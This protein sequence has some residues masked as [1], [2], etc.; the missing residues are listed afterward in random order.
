P[1]G[2][3]QKDAIKNQQIRRW[4]ELEDFLGEIWEGRQPLERE[5]WNGEKG[6]VEVE[7]TF[8]NW[9]SFLEHIL[10]S[11][12]PL[13]RAIDRV[14][15][16]E[17]LELILTASERLTELSNGE[18]IHLVNILYTPDGGETQRSYAPAGV[19]E[20]IERNLQLS[21]PTAAIKNSLSPYFSDLKH[22]YDKLLFLDL[23]RLT[24]IPTHQSTPFTPRLRSIRVTDFMRG[25]QA[26]CQLIHV[27]KQMTREIFHSTCFSAWR[28]ENERSFLKEKRRWEKQ[29]GRYARPYLDYLD[30][31]EENQ[32][33]VFW[34]Q[35]GEDLLLLLVTGEVKR[36]TTEAFILNPF[37]DH[38]SLWHRELTEGAHRGLPWVTA[39]GTLSALI[40]PLSPD[41]S[42]QLIG[43]MRDFRSLTRPLLGNYRTLR[44]SQGPQTEQ[45]LALAFYPVQGYGY[46][47]SQ[48]YRQA[49][50]Q[51]SLF[52]ILTAYAALMQR[53]SSLNIDRPSLHNLNP[54]IMTDSNH[55]EG[56]K[57]CVGYDADGRPIPLYFKGGVLPRS[58]AKQLGKLDIVK[59]LEKS[60]N[61]YFSLLASEIIGAESF[62]ECSKLWGFGEK[63]EIALPGEVKG[64]LPID[65]S[66]NRSGLYSFAI[67]QHTLIVTPLQSANFLGAIASGG[68]LY[69]PSISL[70]EPLPPIKRQLNLPPSVKNVLFKAMEQ[71]ADN[72]GT[73][74][75]G[76]YRTRFKGYSLEPLQRE[77]GRFIGKTSTAECVE[78]VCLDRAQ[79]LET[80]NH[81]WFGSIHFDRPNREGVEVRYGNPELVVIVY[82]RFGSYGREAIPIACEVAQKW[83]E[84]KARSQLD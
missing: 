68:C 63:T 56:N 53:Y 18:C 71:V 64:F 26:K 15:T 2:D 10:I 29:E 51:G 32:F 58:I 35:W 82:L 48:A 28:T 17:E 7:R 78:S 43:A 39:Y 31:E 30:A 27:V 22:T 34:D 14:K 52:K 74:G 61:P 72:A 25:T 38:F 3:S 36:Q 9:E 57:W 49:A 12:S 11:G 75:M 67:G 16:L 24:L 60:S 54:L 40:E 77:L 79:N 20:E 45:D 42:R 73:K 5:R 8:L 50:T 21:N 6:Q 66:Y 55:K 44:H 33:N 47:R 83:R 41:E 69:R 80:Y 62:L 37:L 23:C 46:A 81:I 1:S 4:F 84:I 13:Q 19:K 76:Y 65:L 70:R 59:A